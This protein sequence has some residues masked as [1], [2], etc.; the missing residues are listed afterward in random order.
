MRKIPA[1]FLI[2]FLVFSVGVGK[3]ENQT[4][5]V[6]PTGMN[7]QNVINQAITQA[8]SGGTV[9]LNAGTYDITGP[10][11]MVSNLKLSG[12]SNAIIRVSSSSSQYFTGTTGIISAHSPVENVEISGFQIDGNCENLPSSYNSNDQDPHDCE[13]AIFIIGS[14]NPRGN[15][16]YIHDMKIYDCFSDGIHVRFCNGV[17]VSNIEESNCQHEGIY[18]C[19]VLQGEISGCKIAGMTSDCM[20]VENSQNVTVH[21]NLFFS[22]N[23]TH[24]NGAYEGGANALQIANQGRSFGTGSP[25][26]DSTANIE[27]FNNTFANVQINAA[28]GLSNIFIHDNKFIGKSELETMGVP[29]DVSGATPTIQQSEQVFNSIF[30][31]LNMTFSDTGIVDNHNVQPGMNWQQKGHSKAWV[32]IVGWNNLTQINGIFY[33]PSGE[34]PIVKYGTVATELTGSTQIHLTVSQSNGNATADLEVITT[35][36]IANKTKTE[37]S[38]Y[39]DTEKMPETFSSAINNT[40]YV[41]ILNNSFSKQTVVY[42]PENPD[43]MKICFKFNNSETWHYLHTGTTNTTSKGVKFVNISSLDYWNPEDNV[44]GNQFVISEYIS[45]KDIKSKVQIVQYDVYGNQISI[46]NY[47][48]KEDAPLSFWKLLP[49]QTALFALIVGIFVYG[50]YRNLEAFR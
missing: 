19:E 10:I 44:S 18:F 46:T 5:T 32:D 26:P 38:H 4:V 6:S 31:I 48:I 25:K 45:P 20:R 49:P 9:F 16:V 27:V 40:A 1:F 3:A 24:N 14:T 42:V 29:V 13:R 41:T 21:D 28:S 12:D 7:D 39:F 23:G 30:D 36:S 43:V 33:I 8:G 35:Y 11:E 17:R 2:L 15:G 22:Y 37:V 47:E 50:S 34:Q